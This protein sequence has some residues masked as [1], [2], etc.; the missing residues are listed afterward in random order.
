MG[1]HD[2]CRAA[3]LLCSFVALALGSEARESAVGDDGWKFLHAY[4]RHMLVRRGNVSVDGRLDDE[5]WAKAEW[6][7]NEFVD[8]T[9]HPLSPVL[10]SVPSFQQAEV[11]AMWD[12]EYF[13]VGARLRDPI[14][15]ATVPAGHNG[16][17][18]PYVD[19][20]FEVFIDPS[21]TA[22]FYKEFEMNVLNATYDVNWGVPDDFSLECDS[23]ANHSAPYLPTCVNTSSHFY[24]GNWTMFNGNNTDDGGKDGHPHIFNIWFRQTECYWRVDR[25]GS[26]PH[27]CRTTPWRYS[28]H[29]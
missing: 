13:C 20:D 17:S 19:N 16:A 1:G 21:G 6:H 24:S 2:R 9:A 18:V 25:R 22:Q 26:V 8:I 11:A 14:I 28:G 29:R 10:D 3:L 15:Y 23:S 27:P 12:D 7:S 4:P 5:A